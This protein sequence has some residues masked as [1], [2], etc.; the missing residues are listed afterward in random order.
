MTLT[1]A[2]SPRTPCSRR[3]R[4]ASEASRKRCWN[5]TPSLMP[6]LSAAATSASARSVERSSGFSS[7]MCLPAAAKRSTSSRWVLGGVRIITALIEASRSIGPRSSASGKAKRSANACRRTALRLKAYATSTRSCRSAKLLAWGVTAMPRPMMARRRLCGMFDRPPGSAAPV[8]HRLRRRRHGAWASRRRTAGGLATRRAGARLSAGPAPRHDRRILSDGGE[9]SGCWSLLELSAACSEAGTPG[10]VP[11]D[12]VAA[13]PIEELPSCRIRPAVP[14]I[15]SQPVGAG[16]A[17]HEHAD[18]AARD[19]AD[20][21]A[22]ELRHLRRRQQRLADRHLDA[23]DRRRLARLG[24][25][26]VGRGAG[27]RRLRRP[28]PDRG[29]RPL[30]RRARRPRRSP[31][32]DQGRAAADHGAVA[33]SCSR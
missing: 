30:R 31:A 12:R 2:S 14:T 23:A 21:R 3:A 7:R 18:R 19:R 20:P 26:P 24:A 5:T 9:P 13:A 25:Q 27:P 32:G 4:S 1:A 15:R 17:L 11:P 28:V 10:G 6:A 16:L 29:D 8:L 33:A 22:P